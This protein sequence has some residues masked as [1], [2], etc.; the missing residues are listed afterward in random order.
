MECT[1][2]DVIPCRHPQCGRMTTLGAGWCP[3]HLHA[4]FGIEIKKSTIPNAGSGVF[5]TRNIQ[6][7]E[8]I[9]TYDGEVVDT[10]EL[11]RRYGKHARKIYAVKIGN[12]R[13]EDGLFRRGAGTMVNH[14]DSPNAML[15]LDSDTNRV[16]IVSSKRIRKNQEIFVDYG[17]NYW[18]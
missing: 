3:E 16:T 14:S 9:V 6:A 17:P 7:N 15:V 10:H 1:I 4:R 18:I 11:N 2:C 13:F 12:G 5:A 8:F